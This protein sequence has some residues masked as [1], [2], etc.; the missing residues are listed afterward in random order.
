MRTRKRRLSG[1]ER[2]ARDFTVLVA[3]EAA[4]AGRRR[5]CNERRFV[6]WAGQVLRSSRGK[7]E[8][9]ADLVGHKLGWLVYGVSIRAAERVG[10]RER[11]LVFARRHRHVLAEQ[12][13]ASNVADEPEAVPLGGGGAGGAGGVAVLLVSKK[14]A[15]NLT[16]TAGGGK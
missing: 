2:F 9:L 5:V 10:C 12:V 4:R 16:V 11:A 6:T 14:H 15:K 7:I 8:R 13:L 3:Q 1:P